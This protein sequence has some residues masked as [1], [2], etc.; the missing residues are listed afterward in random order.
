MMP[1]GRAG[2]TFAAGALN[3]A[4]KSLMEAGIV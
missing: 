4:W 1:H 2:M 3:G